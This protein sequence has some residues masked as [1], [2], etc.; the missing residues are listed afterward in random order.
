M[1]KYLKLN[2]KSCILV[3]DDGP[4]VPKHITIIVHIIKICCV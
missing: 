3:P 4:N 2:L 1:N